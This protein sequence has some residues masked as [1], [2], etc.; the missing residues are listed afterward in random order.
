MD[1]CG[2]FSVGASHLEW[3]LKE[4]YA[5]GVCAHGVIFHAPAVSGLGE[6]LA[7]NEDER[8]GESC[9]TTCGNDTL[10]KADGASAEFADFKGDPTAG[11]QDAMY[12]IQSAGHP[13]LPVCE[14]CVD[15]DR[16][17]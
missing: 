2:H 12:F 17:S 11:A 1:G 9:A 8:G 15:A 13:S 10:L 3:F 16:G 7:I 14:L 6:L 5:V 4:H